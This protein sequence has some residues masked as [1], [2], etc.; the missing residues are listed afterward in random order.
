MAVA[1]VFGLPEV[2][3][4]GIVNRDFDTQGMIT[5]HLRL[6]T[7]GSCGLVTKCVTTAAF[8]RGLVGPPRSWSTLIR[9][10]GRPPELLRDE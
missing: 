6:A 1:P 8:T 10:H 4:R 5:H 2:C 7:S 3:H 9:A